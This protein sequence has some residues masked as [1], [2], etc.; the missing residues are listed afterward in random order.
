MLQID[1][2]VNGFLAQFGAS[3]HIFEFLYFSLKTISSIGG[4]RLGIFGQ[5]RQRFPFCL[6]LGSE[7][8]VAFADGWL[9]VLLAVKGAGGNIFSL[10]H[11]L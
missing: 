1:V 8:V 4:H 7:G 3:F 9:V 5:Q 11:Q 10:P 2:V 6:R